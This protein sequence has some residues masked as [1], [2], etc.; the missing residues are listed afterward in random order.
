MSVRFRKA[1]GLGSEA[2]AGIRGRGGK[3]QPLESPKD[4]FPAF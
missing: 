3:V 1:P 4:L 2:A